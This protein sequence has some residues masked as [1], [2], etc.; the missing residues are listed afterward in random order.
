MN[1]D[2]IHNETHWTRGFG[3]GL[4]YYGTDG[5]LENGKITI[6]F[7]NDEY[8]NRSYLNIRAKYRQ[9]TTETSYLCAIDGSFSTDSPI[10]FGVKGR[11]DNDWYRIQHISV[12]A[13][14][15]YW[16]IPTSWCESVRPFNASNSSSDLDDKY[17][18]W[19]WSNNEW[20][21]FTEYQYEQYDDNDTN[22]SLVLDPITNHIVH[23][24]FDGEDVVQQTFGPLV[25]H[26][27]VTMELE[28][29][30][31]VNV[32]DWWWY[33]VPDGVYIQMEVNGMVFTYDVP[34]EVDVCDGD[35]SAVM[36]EEDLQFCTKR[37][38]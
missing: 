33:D 7:R 8:Q 34:D 4:D 23:G 38:C 11:N 13:C 28:V 5:G 24:I 37:M 30:Y 20:F 36:N 3:Q 27:I 18:F 12:S 15:G 2:D 14:S 1:S 29:W 16:E 25:E 6:R 35:W 32:L 26:E 17:D 31:R 9:K 21:N 19:R 22:D 10:S